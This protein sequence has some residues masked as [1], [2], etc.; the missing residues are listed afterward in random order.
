MALSSGKVIMA[1]ISKNRSITVVLG[2]GKMERTGI[3][4]ALT[5]GLCSNLM[6]L[7]IIEAT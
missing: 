4:S 2:W 7:S 5:E 6:G 1:V 3:G